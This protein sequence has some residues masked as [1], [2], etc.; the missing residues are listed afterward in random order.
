MQSNIAGHI[1]VIGLLLMRCQH[2]LAIPGQQLVVIVCP[3]L[4][5]IVMSERQLVIV[6]QEIL[7]VVFLV[8]SAFVCIGVSIQVAPTIVARI[9]A[10]AMSERLHAIVMLE[11]LAIACQGVLATV[12]QEQHVVVTA[13]PQHHKTFLDKGLGKDD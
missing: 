5:V 4:V 7:V 11:E 12:I 10:I 1:V 2:A 9:I 13:E 6:M 3:E 8:A